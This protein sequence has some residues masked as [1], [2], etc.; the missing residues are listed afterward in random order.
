MAKTFRRAVNVKISAVK[1][2]ITANKKIIFA[3]AAFAVLGLLLSFGKISDC[4]DS[5]VNSIIGLIVKG[6]FGF[7]SFEFRLALFMLVPV[8]VSFL[9]SFNYYVFLLSFVGVT[10]ISRCFFR[11]IIETLVCD[12][13]YGLLS[14]VFILLPVFV[15]FMI[16]FLYF[17]GEMC[18]LIGCPPCK[19]V[20]YVT[21]YRCYWGSTKKMLWN[22]FLYT[23]LPCFIYANVIVFVFYL[24]CNV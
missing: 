17:I 20:F 9:L 6:D 23:F 13:F 3:G 21:Q 11:Y 7:V 8:A 10:I 4:S 24:I 14:F 2:K 16:G 1:S 19:K 22:F 5:C 18:D 15:G 12:T